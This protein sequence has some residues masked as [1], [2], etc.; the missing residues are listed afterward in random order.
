MVE[1]STDILLK[2][3]V[4]T[5]SATKLKDYAQV[6]IVKSK[7]ALYHGR[8][9]DSPFSLFGEVGKGGSHFIEELMNGCLKLGTLVH[10]SERSA[11]E[12]GE[13]ACESS[14]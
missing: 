13:N 5:E 7:L 12:F 6:G 9:T 8:Q 11:G 10:I 4:V 1:K 14:Y 3:A 2:G